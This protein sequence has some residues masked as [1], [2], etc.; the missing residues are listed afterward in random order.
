M[1]FEYVLWVLYF[2]NNLL[3]KCKITSQS[4]VVFILKLFFD[5]NSLWLYISPLQIN[6]TSFNTGR[7]G[8]FN[9]GGDGAEGLPTG[10]PSQAPSCGSDNCSIGGANGAASYNGQNSGGSGGGSGS[11]GSAGTF[12]S[13]GGGG[14]KERA[15]A[16]G[17]DGE[18]T[19][20]FIRIA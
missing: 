20:R 16:A 3:Y 18:I 2:C 10:G 15:G 19:Y 1:I 9:S 6:I 4:H 5:I 11:S 17:G 14:G 7:A 12:G 8:T 13:G